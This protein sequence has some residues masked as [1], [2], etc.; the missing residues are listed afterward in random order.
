MLASIY[1]CLLESQSYSTCNPGGRACIFSL[2]YIESCIEDIE[3]KIL[4]N[5]S[6]T[7][8]PLLPPPF[9]THGT[10]SLVCFIAAALTFIPCILLFCKVTLIP[11]IALVLFPRYCKRLVCVELYQ[12]LIELERIFILPLAPR[13]VRQSYLSKRLHAI[14]Y[15]CGLSRPFLASLPVSNSVGWIFL[16]A[17]VCFISK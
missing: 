14:P 11:V 7:K 5:W 12:W 4:T 10:V 9:H 3:P 15:T 8:P 17:L 2:S 16:C 6:W 13:W 1:R